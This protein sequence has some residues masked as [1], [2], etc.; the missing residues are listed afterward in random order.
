MTTWTYTLPD[1]S[2]VLAEEHTLSD[3]E[4]RKLAA[5]GG[6]VRSGLLVLPSRPARTIDVT[7]MSDI[8]PRYVPG[9]ASETLTTAEPNTDSYYAAGSADTP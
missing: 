8:G 1:G 2:Q 7:T 3:D 4:M 5:T 6:T 9:R